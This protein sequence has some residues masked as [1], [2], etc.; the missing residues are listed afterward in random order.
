MNYLQLESLTY[1]RQV[2]ILAN[3]EQRRLADTAIT[4]QAHPWL[5][6]GGQQLI[7]FGQQLLSSPATRALPCPSETAANRGLG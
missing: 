3:A 5:V 1:D 7:R 4:A 2:T 6:W